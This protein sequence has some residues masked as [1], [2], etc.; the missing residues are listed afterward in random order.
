MYGFSISTKGILTNNYYKKIG[1]Y[2]EPEPQGAYIMIRKIGDEIILNQDFD[3]SFGIYIYENKETNYFAL[4]NSFLLLEEY[5]VGKQNFTLNKDFAES[6]FITHLCIPSIYETLVNEIILAPSNA[7]VIINTKRKSLKIY[8]IDYNENSIPFESEE[9]LEIIDKWADKW[10]YILRSLKKQTDNISF[11]LSGGFDTRAVLSILLNSGIDLNDILIYSIYN[12]YPPIKQDFKIASNISL[13]F[14]FKINN[15]ILDNNG[16]KLSTK[17]SL[18]C[19][20]YSKLGFHKE[21]YSPNKFF[22]KPKFLISGGGGEIIR[23]FPGF[24]IKTWINIHSKKGYN[25]GFYN[26]FDR[27]CNRSIFLLKRTKTYYNDYEIS[28]DFYVKGRL[29]HHFGKQCLEKFLVNSYL[30]QP[31]IDPDIK[32]IKFDINEKSSHDLIAYIYVRFA[33]DLINFPF[34]G[35]RKLNSESIIK[36]EKLNKKFQPYKTKSDYNESFYIDTERKSPVSPSNDTKSV[37]EYLT[38][39]CRSS[40]FIHI[41]NQLYD[42]NIYNCS[43]YINTNS[44]DFGHIYALF[45]VAKTLEDLSLNKRYLNNI[46]IKNSCDKGKKNILF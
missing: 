19:S 10:S 15:L 44:T 29:R 46:N 22:S 1:H 3:G 36:A 8:Y 16:T 4:S 33:H 23:G 21:F 5:L 26:S 24:P 13:K 43:K 14:G 12:E 7:F 17:D 6:L 25:K 42:N 35:K 39:L 34:E 30:F 45:A 41:I 28:A 11:D 27:V 32:Q 31:L 40:K 37:K 2:E 18:F 20:I 9:G 38:E